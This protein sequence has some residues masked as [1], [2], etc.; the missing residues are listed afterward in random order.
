MLMSITL[1]SKVYVPR[2]KRIFL[3]RG[4][5]SYMGPRCIQPSASNGRLQLPLELR[6][7]FFSQ[8]ALNLDDPVHVDCVCPLMGWHVSNCIIALFI[9][10][11]QRILHSSL[12]TLSL[13]R[14]GLHILC[15]IWDSPCLTDSVSLPLLIRHP[16]LSG[17][18]H[19]FLK[20]VNTYNA[21][22]HNPSKGVVIKLFIPCKRI[23]KYIFII[24]IRS[25]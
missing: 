12:N 17:K 4:G 9:R 21:I 7:G 20:R 5:R 25:L 3:G 16:G 23:P 14:M 19:K 1:G 2:P 15:G 24:R 11:A 8:I 13:W 10:K 6:E 18:Y 22:E